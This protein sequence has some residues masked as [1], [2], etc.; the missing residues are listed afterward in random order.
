[1]AKYRLTLTTADGCKSVS[2]GEVSEAHGYAFYMLSMACTPGGP[3]DLVKQAYLTECQ[4]Q[5]D[6][7]N[8]NKGAK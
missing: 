6:E 1:M 8:A 3:L 4:R 5:L 2:K 7:A